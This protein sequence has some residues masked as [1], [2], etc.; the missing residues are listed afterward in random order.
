MGFWQF[1]TT[2][3]SV[4]SSFIVCTQP[5]V[6][7]QSELSH[8]AARATNWTC[9][10]IH[11]VFAQTLRLITKPYQK[12]SNLKTLGFEVIRVRRYWGLQILDPDSAYSITPCSHEKSSD[13][14]SA[15]FSKFPSI[16]VLLCQTHSTL[17][18]FPALQLEATPISSHFLSSDK[19]MTPTYRIIRTLTQ[20][21]TTSHTSVLF[22]PEAS[23]F[24]LLFFPFF[25]TFSVIFQKGKMCFECEAVL[26]LL[27]AI[28]EHGLLEIQ[29]LQ[30]LCCC[31]RG[32]FSESEG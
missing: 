13:E 12:A 31:R 17:S 5:C 29:D 24:F 9:K 28:S 23:S 2:Q 14:E 3:W 1:C 16:R 11:Y 6:R 4:C 20:P 26:G 32:W 18:S 27:L 22:F 8:Q 7:V 25:A 21:P 10:L 15:K 30:G 19:V